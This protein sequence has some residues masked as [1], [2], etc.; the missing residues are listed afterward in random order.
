MQLNKK[1]QFKN[2]EAAIH[3]TI[4]EIIQIKMCGYIH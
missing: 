2:T 1:V 3:D 4:L